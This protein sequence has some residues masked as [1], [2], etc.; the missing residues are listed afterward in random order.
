M[1]R[2]R[3]TPVFTAAALLTL[4]LAVGG[5]T[6]AFAV[7]DR[8]L[9]EPLPYPDSDRLVDIGYGVPGYGFDVLPFSVGTFVH[10]RAEQ[11]SLSEMAIYFDADRYNLGIE[12]PERVP[13]AR[14][15]SGFFEVFRSPPELGRTFREGDERVGADPVAIVSHDLWRRRWGADASI[16]GRKIHVEGVDREVVGVARE[17]F[18][19]PDRR[20]SLWIPFTIDP[21]NLN[22]MGFGYPGVGRLAPGAS[23]ESAREDIARVTGG[24]GEV[25]PDRLTPR[26]AADGRF[27]SY[28]RP[29]KTRVVG[30]VSA[31]VW[32]VFGTA[33]LLLLLAT[34]NL[35]NLFL[36]R[37]EGRE[38]ERAVR[39]ALGSSRIR[40]LA[41]P[42]SEGLVVGA[43]G[44]VGGA[45]L[46]AI[47]LAVVV[48]VAPP[49]LPRIDEIGLDR[50]AL[51]FG[52]AV[53]LAASVAFALLPAL[54]VR[55]ASPHAGL[56]SGG[57]GSTRSRGAR[58]V[59]GALVANQAAVA[60]ALLVAAGLLA[61]SAGNLARVDPGFR[62][63]GVI[64]FE[65][66]LPAE[67]Y[68]ADDRAR[69]WVRIADRIERI[70]A[71][72]AAG[73]GEFLPLSPDFRKGPL[74]VE[75]EDLPEGQAGPIVD[76][77]R[78]TPRYFEALDIPLIEGRLL[79]R[80]DGPG[81][82]AAV[83]VDQVLADRHLGGGPAVGRR[84][85]ITPRG[86]YMEVVGVV[87]S[88]RSE[89]FREEPIPFVYLPSDATTP[90][91]PEVAT[92]M[93]FAARS[94]EP[95]ERLVHL[96][97]EAVAEIDPGLPLGS[98]RTIESAVQDHLARQ[99]FV[100]WVLTSM[101]AMGLALA[102]V[103]VYGVVAYVVVG[104]RREIGLK[105]ALGA[106]APGLLASVVG[107]GL[108]A[109][110]AG[111]VAGVLVALLAGRAVEGLLFGVTRADPL[112]YGLALVLIVGT[113]ALASLPP[114]WRV[115]R[116]DPN[117]VLREE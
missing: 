93:T 96:L 89:S 79:E 6:A 85:R 1:R 105:I 80:D 53:A 82:H 46:A 108:A 106:R 77:N 59:Q 13:V 54:A 48:R 38:R 11:R 8:L 91:S 64:T 102:A 110:G 30:D 47:L 22:P 75:G 100:V 58:R 117:A 52:V 45:G 68:G 103:G 111:A 42:L 36:V 23:L 9:L 33:A 14:V 78:V 81:G 67:E 56:R 57:P 98:V 7:A 39:Q 24:L 92:T 90:S 51:A 31:E 49:D 84:I 15:T 2:L 40:L 4:S 55:R 20:T 107:S 25:Y 18:R 73:G 99:D 27:H 26:W 97:T 29:L 66:G 95:P 32:L 16:I 50:G 115:S 116:L 101:A 65:I 113:A 63:T 104:R 35:A 43:A 41:A 44:G 72:T 71:V 17:G 19:Y 60:V 69:A 62:A 112:T 3:A 87:G 88:V 94:D 109:V 28:V 37:L 74:H 114:A 61:R 34:T 70:G 86:E 10:T 76:L 5:I 83:V 21:S 12:R